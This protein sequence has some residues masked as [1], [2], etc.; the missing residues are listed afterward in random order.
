MQMSRQQIILVDQDGVLANFELACLEAWR[1]RYPDLPFV[2]LEERTT[3]DIKVQYETLGEGFGKRMRD[4]IHGEGFYA[5]L[6]PIDG[7]IEAMN[8]MRQLGFEVFICTAPARNTRCIAEKAEWIGK[9]LGADWIG[10]LIATRDK[11][12]VFGDVLIDDKPRINGLVTPHFIHILYDQ[13]YNRQVRR[14]RLTWKN[15]CDVIPT[16]V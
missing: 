5:T 15:W 10:K 6:Q 11:T 3:H 8:E 2:P 14:S 1:Q 13:P 12:L 7:A 9:H 16:M 4:I